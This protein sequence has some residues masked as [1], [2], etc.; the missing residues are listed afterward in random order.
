MLGI[1]PLSGQAS[2]MSALL[3]FGAGLFP[4]VGAGLY[5]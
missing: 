2:S 1:W 5:L 3:T 4:V